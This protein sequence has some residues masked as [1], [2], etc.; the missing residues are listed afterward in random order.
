MYE[1]NHELMLSGAGLS[2]KDECQIGARKICGPRAACHNTVGSYACT[3]MGGFRPSNHRTSFT[4]N[5]GTYCQGEGVGL[6]TP[7]GG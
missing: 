4:P 6:L 5:D 2:D 7:C 3:C 1:E